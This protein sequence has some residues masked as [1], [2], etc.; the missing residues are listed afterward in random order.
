MK[1]RTKN[2]KRE[3][4]SKTFFLLRIRHAVCSCSCYF[5]AAT[6]HSHSVAV[7][8]VVVFL[9]VVVVV[10]VSSVTECM[11]SGL[12]EEAAVRKRPKSNRRPTRW[13]PGCPLLPSVAPFSFWPRSRSLTL[14]RFGRSEARR[15]EA[16][17]LREARRSSMANSLGH[18][19]ENKKA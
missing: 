16:A 13:K 4:K 17:A 7:L 3:S 19:A 11:S 6:V 8:V 2:K 10:V 14:A 15:G 1:E 18:G 9:V 12:A 5:V